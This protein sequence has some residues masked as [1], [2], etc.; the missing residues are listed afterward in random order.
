[1]NSNQVNFV[2]YYCRMLE[3]YLSGK[4]P[5]E[6]IV[7]LGTDLRMLEKEFP[8]EVRRECWNWH[9]RNNSCV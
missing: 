2:R 3:K 4:F 7:S 8:S 1:M 6:K 5:E 9:K